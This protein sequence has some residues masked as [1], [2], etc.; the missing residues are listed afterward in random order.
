VVLYGGFS[1]Q[2]CHR[3]QYL[4][5]DRD[6]KYGPLFSN[7]LEHTGIRPLL[8]PARTPQAN[9]NQARPHQGVE[10]QVPAWME[11]GS[12]LPAAGPIIATPVL[13]IN[14]NMDSGGSGQLIPLD[15]DLAEIGVFFPGNQVF[16]R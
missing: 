12:P 1:N 4:I 14:V 8:I 16:C 2:L 6:Q 5:H 7:L 9:D 13:Q 10:Q 15:S 11:Q 3:P